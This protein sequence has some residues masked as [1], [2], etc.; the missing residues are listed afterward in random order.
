MYNQIFTKIA[1]NI[2]FNLKLHMV[3][4]LLDEGDHSGQRN[5]F[6]L[7]GAIEPLLTSLSLFFLEAI[8]NYYHFKGTLMDI[9]HYCESFHS[10]LIYFF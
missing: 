9:A 5:Y 10:S 1:P 2:N 3:S 8:R 4:Q 6:P 7:Q